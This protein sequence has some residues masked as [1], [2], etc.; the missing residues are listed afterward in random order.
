[1]ILQQFDSV[2]SNTQAQ[3]YLL[4]GGIK[5]DAVEYEQIAE[6]IQ[7]VIVTTTTKSI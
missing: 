3:G 2:T 4:L 5:K 6:A 1:L 7:N